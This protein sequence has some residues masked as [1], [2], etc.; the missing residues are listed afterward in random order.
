VL[1]AAGILDHG[2][3]ANV[4]NRP[5]GSARASNAIAT[6]ADR[7]APAI[8]AVRVVGKSGSRTGSGV[9]IRHAGQVLTS[10][11]LVAGATRV[12]VVTSGGKVQ[13]AKVIG[14]DAASDLA[15][16]DIDGDLEAAD[17]AGAGSLR[18]GEAVYAV[19]ADASGTPWVSEGIVSSLA[20][21]VAGG[22][23]TMSG[24]IES[25]ALTEPA[26]A[27]GAL[28]DAEGRV[29]G[30]LMTPVAG[31]PAAVAV[32]IKFA[33]QVAESL[34]AN[35]RVDHGWLG[36]QAAATTRGDLVITAL[37]KGGPSEQA[38]L[39]VGDLVVNVDSQPIA[40]LDDL[41]ATARRH[42]PGDRIRLVITR[43]RSDLTVSVR[44]SR[45]PRT[46]V[47]ETTPPSTAAPTTVP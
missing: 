31:H 22:G 26:I 1:A 3:P 18:L 35:G 6:M 13:T 46:V 43:G 29:A 20:G 28:L 37:A 36:I 34:R 19:G 14:R 24:L 32:P 39:E 30:I 42:W 5:K 47:E 44:L 21:R 8:V 10:D 17:L 2:S 23:T 25:N 4:A 45:M 41:M 38:G 12:D 33:S 40:T 9:C 7:V 27:G 16:L 11:R 15:L